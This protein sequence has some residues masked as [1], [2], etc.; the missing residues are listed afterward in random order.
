M[1][2]VIYKNS[3]LASI[4]SLFGSAAVAMGVMALFSG[5]LGILPGIAVI[6]VGVALIWLGS[7]ISERKARKKQQKAQQAAQA[8][9][10]V[11]PQQA[12]QTYQ[13][14]QPQR[15]VP[16]QQ[17][18]QTRLET[19]QLVSRTVNKSAVLA[20][21]CFLLAALMGIG[22][23][24]LFTMSRGRYIGLEHLANMR[25]IDR[26]SMV[27]MVEAIAALI[28]GFTCFRMKKTQKPSGMQVLALLVMCGINALDA[29]DRYFS[30]G[31]GGYSDPSGIHYYVFASPFLRAAA[32]LLL[33]LI[34]IF[35]RS[36]NKANR[37]G[38]ARFLWIVAVLMLGLGWSKGIGDSYVMDMLDMVIFRGGRLSLRSE[39]LDLL[40]ILFQVCGALIVGFCYQ[41]LC[42]K[43]EVTYVQQV[44]PVQTAAPVQQMP[45]QPA[46]PVQP[47]A[48]VQ[49]VA[50]QHEPRYTAPAAPVQPVQQT[51][52]A[53]APA[54]SAEVEKTIRAYK[55]LL[56]CG[57]L[58]QEEY[59]QKIREL[60]RQ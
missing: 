11:Q 31:F 19:T 15:I 39:Y 41:R 8:Q 40:T 56:D 21:A 58:S 29:L 44:A 34:A 16:A 26:N 33:A 52:T 57:I 32:Y 7:V 49:P 46:V 4:C 28:M 23:V 60:G 17:P 51:Y 18:V 3:I 43:Q 35:A 2:F 5:E 53:P 54:A 45:V 9:R 12:P 38:L 14:A 24:C 1:R 59:D 6:A 30:Y 25:S 47:A 22:A 36:S 50:P 55:D 42:S 20:G 48:P 13:A 37:G 27:L 10:P